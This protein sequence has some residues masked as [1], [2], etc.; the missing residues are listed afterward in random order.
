MLFFT[1][2][3]VLLR[4]GLSAALFHSGCGSGLVAMSTVQTRGNQKWQQPGRACHVSFV[5]P[6][7]FDRHGGKRVARIRTEVLGGFV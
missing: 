6:A 5:C 4:D 2:S 3:D 7:Q 1:F